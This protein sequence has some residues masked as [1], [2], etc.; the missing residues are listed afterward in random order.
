MT[1]LADP[2]LELARRLQEERRWS[3]AATIFEHVLAA[4][5]DREDV[6]RALMHNHSAAG[7]TLEALKVLAD[8]RVRYPDGPELA[9]DVAEQTQ[10]AI[11]RYNLHM[12]SKDVAQAAPYASALADLTPNNPLVLRTAMT[13]NQTVG[14][15]ESAGR[16]A[17]TLLA[18]DPEDISAHETMAE[19]CKA[20]GDQAGDLA[21]R[22]RVAL[23]DRPS[24]HPLV[25]LKDI[26][27]V[28]SGLLCGR[29]DDKAV[30]ELEKLLAAQEQHKVSE[31]EDS[32]WPGWERHYRLLLESIDLPAVL[33]PTPAPS[34]EPQTVYADANGQSMTWNDVA[35]RADTLDAK[36][37]FLVAADQAYVELYARWYV[38]SILK[39]C[40]V[41]FLVVVHVIGGAEHLGRSATTVDVHDDR[42]IFA[43]DA[44]DE[45]GVTTKVYDAP[46]KGMASKPVGHFQSIR[47]LQAGGLLRR[48]GRPLFISDIDLLLQRGV[49]DLLERCEGADLVFNENQNSF[50]AG[51]RLTANLVLAYP[52]PVTDLFFR[53]VSA[54]LGQMLDRP[55]LTRWIDQVAL[56]LGRHHLHTHAEPQLQ[57]F[58]VTSDINNVM[59]RT[60]QENPFRFLSLY[61]GFDTSSLEAD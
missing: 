43:G 47:F 39:H 22:S 32:G 31:P 2:I 17:Q 10:P 26:H 56:M 19:V 29:L 8:L 57:Y 50:N 21:H 30:A 13:C 23:L 36:V 51:A 37:V 20:R 34:P 12:R 1:D 25:R 38:R 58:D 59:Y 45:A 16:Y 9:R 33:G 7:R 35:K 24:Q 28:A 14:D 42:L 53:F 40:D 6:L 11:E 15:L 41:P 61:H 55:V 52:T 46:P 18:L 4:Q 3:D 5:P 49:S 27:D 54:Y 44:F 48:L 60:W